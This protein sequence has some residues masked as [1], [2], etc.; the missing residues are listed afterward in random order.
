MPRPSIPAQESLQRHNPLFCLA[1][2]NISAVVATIKNYHFCGN[3]T[4]CTGEG[5]DVWIKVSV[6][7][8]SNKYGEIRNGNKYNYT[9]NKTN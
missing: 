3:G 1:A 8:G 9:A 4:H 2:K 6:E 7:S 5:N